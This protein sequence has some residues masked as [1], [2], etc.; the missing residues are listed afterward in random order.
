MLRTT[1][2]AVQV[3]DRVVWIGPEPACAD[4][5]FVGCVARGVTGDPPR[6]FWVRDRYEAWRDLV[7]TPHA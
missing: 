2:G 5:F 3:E 4:F 1:L 6:N 7:W